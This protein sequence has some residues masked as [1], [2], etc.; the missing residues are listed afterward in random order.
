MTGCHAREHG[1]RQR[2]LAEHRFA[3]CRHRQ[4]ARRGDAERVHRL[5][6]DVL[7]QHRP[8][9][10]PSVAATRV[11]GWAGALQ[12]NVE[13]IAGGG[14]LFAEQDRPP[15]SER[16]EV[17][18]LM[19]RVGLRQWLRLV[20]QRVAG[21]DCGAMRAVQRVGV[22]AQRLGQRPVEHHE[23]RLAHRRRR[24]SGVEHR[25]E[26]RVG[27]IPVASQPSIQSYPEPRARP[28]TKRA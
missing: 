5:A 6:D 25:G 22:E 17:S 7:A 13:A 8:E 11:R 21:E 18:E 20:R 26:P 24:H 1:A 19:A 28:S 12:L 4:A 16:G 23:P 15:V 2:P 9:R 14:D 27:V 3:G 10:G